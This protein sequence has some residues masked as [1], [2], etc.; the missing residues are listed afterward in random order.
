MMKEMVSHRYLYL[1][2]VQHAVS[3]VV[4]VPTI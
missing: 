3:L 1:L 2:A 4:R